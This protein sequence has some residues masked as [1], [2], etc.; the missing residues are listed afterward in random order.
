MQLYSQPEIQDAHESIFIAGKPTPPSV[1]PPKTS[2]AEFDALLRE[3]SS[4]VGDTNV[5]SGAGLINFVDPFG[6][7]QEYVPSAAVW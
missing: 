1:L 7:H 3:L 4:I 5:V 6:L 2:Q